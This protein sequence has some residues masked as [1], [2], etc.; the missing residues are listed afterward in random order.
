VLRVPVVDHEG[1]LIGVVGV[2][3]DLAAFCGQQRPPR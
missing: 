3:D 2:T 1:I